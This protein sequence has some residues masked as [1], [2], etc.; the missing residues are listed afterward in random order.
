MH[1]DLF[2]H[3][4]RISVS[5]KPAMNNST[6]IQQTSNDH[7]LS[8]TSPPP[9]RQQWSHLTAARPPTDGRGRGGIL[10]DAHRLLPITDKKRRRQQ[11]QLRHE[12]SPDTTGRQ[13]IP[14]GARKGGPGSQKHTS[15]RRVAVAA[16]AAAFTAS[17]GFAFLPRFPF[18]FAFAFPFPFSLA[19]RPLLLR[20]LFPSESPLSSLRFDKRGGGVGSSVYSCARRDGCCRCRIIQRANWRFSSPR[21][22]RYLGKKHASARRVATDKTS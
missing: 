1:P 4:Q 3:E 8:T 14:R 19:A 10:E 15:A 20:F 7:V 18:A 11:R 12:Q 21:W 16:A 22:S 5:L 13:S 17:D 6:C 9:P 2:P